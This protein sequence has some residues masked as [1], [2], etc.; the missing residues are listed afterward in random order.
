MQGVVKNHSST[1]FLFHK[2]WLCDCGD[3][4]E[5]AKLKLINFPLIH[6]ERDYGDFDRFG[7]MEHAFVAMKILPSGGEA[8]SCVVM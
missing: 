6:Y 4:N 7:P 8:S 1:H 3:L 5:I 2:I